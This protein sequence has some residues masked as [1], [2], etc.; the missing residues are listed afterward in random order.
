MPLWDPYNQEHSIWGLYQGGPI[1]YR[2]FSQ[3]R[4]LGRVG[5]IGGFRV[6]EATSGIHAAHVLQNLD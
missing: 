2:N 6:Q 3:L 1:V 4:S 5:G